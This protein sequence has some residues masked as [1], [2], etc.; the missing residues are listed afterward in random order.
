M[1]QSLGNERRRLWTARDRGLANS[2]HMR[3][4]T[5]RTRASRVPEGKS[6]SLSASMAPSDASSMSARPDAVHVSE[7]M[8]Y[9]SPRESGPLGDAV[10]GGAIWPRL[11]EDLD[12]HRQEP[13]TRSNPR[14]LS[15]WPCALIELLGIPACS[16][17]DRSALLTGARRP[18]CARP[19]RRICVQRKP[20]VG[21]SL[22]SWTDFGPLTPSVSQVTLV[23]HSTRIGGLIV[24]QD[25]TQGEL[26]R[27]TAARSS[28]IFVSRT[29]PKRV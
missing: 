18:I 15:L 29:S 13:L 6:T 17:W 14:L 27:L 4:M 25:G 20:R 26:G 1:L 8:V 2:I 12:G 9:R 5:S 11:R 16:F 3:S 21:R 10:G 24:L 28:P 22:A 23:E 19:A 7:L